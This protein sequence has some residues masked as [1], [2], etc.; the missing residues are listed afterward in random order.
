MKR[1]LAFQFANTYARRQPGWH[2]VSSVYVGPYFGW[3][4]PV[5]CHANRNVRRTLQEGYVYHPQPATF[6]IGLPNGAYRLTLTAYDKVQ[7]RGP[8]CVKANGAFVLRD[9]RTVAGN[10]RRLSFACRVHNRRLSLEFWPHMG[11]DFL[12]N[13]LEVYAPRAVKL[14]PLF[15][16]APATDIPARAVIVRRAENDPRQALRRICDWLAARCP[17]NGYLGDVWTGGACCSYTLAMP[18]RA[19]LAGYD[20]LGDLKYRAVALKALNA[21]ADEQLPTGGW[22]SLFHGRPVSQWGRDERERIVTHG[23]VPLSD[24]GSPVTA[25]AV[26]SQYAPPAEKKRYERAVRRFCD[27]WASRFQQPSGGFTDG[28]WPGFEGKIYSC[29]TAIQAALHAL[30]YRITG[31]PAYRRTAQRALEFLLPDWRADG[32]ML[33]RAPHWFTR[34]GEPFVLEPLHFGDA[35]YYDEGFITVWHHVPEGVFRERVRRALERRVHGSAGL[36]HARRGQVWWPLQD[37]WNNAKSIGMVQTLLFAARHGA[38]TPRLTAALT[39]ATRWLCTPAYAQRV[40]VM[41]EDAERPAALHGLLTWSGMTHEATGFAGMT[42]GEL[43][44]PGVLY[45]AAR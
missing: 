4:D 33:G 14:V 42:L 8:F 41:T 17:A 29:A 9:V 30:A 27:D 44:K 16:T 11:R 20:I 36:L 43:L 19:L 34:N 1:V 26:A 18:V 6:Q 15:K 12:V 25:L 24:I 28:Q 21:F 32:R 37:I 35:W 10:M 13:T 40:G 2:I 5:G 39:D 38:S 45:L 7:N 3:Q 22:D 31:A 23:R